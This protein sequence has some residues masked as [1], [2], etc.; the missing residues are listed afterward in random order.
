MDEWSIT[1][2]AVAKFVLLYA[3]CV[4]GV[5]LCKQIFS[6]CVVLDST[7]C[8]LEQSRLVTSEVREESRA[9][10]FANLVN[11]KLS[12]DVFLDNTGCLTEHTSKYTV[13]ALQ[14]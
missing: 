3:G 8:L 7:G 2:V 5:I 9:D 1:T 14:Q 13:F 12:T 11:L 6:S 4:W 10:N